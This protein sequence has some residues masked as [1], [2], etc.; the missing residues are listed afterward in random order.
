[1]DD[2]ER[3]MALGL[4]IITGCTLAGAMLGAVYGLAIGAVAECLLLGVLSGVGISLLI[5]M[6]I[7]F[8][9]S[10]KALLK[11]AE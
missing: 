8:V 10:V 3:A 7:I 1:M 6:A 5:G 4:A 11:E 2:F 9:R